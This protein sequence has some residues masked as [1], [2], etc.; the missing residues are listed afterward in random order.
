[1][2]IKKIIPWK[3]KP[4]FLKIK[5]LKA[6][7]YKNKHNFKHLKIENIEYKLKKILHVIYQFHINNKIILFIGVPTNLYK[8]MTQLLK[9]TKHIAIPHGIWLNGAI[10]NHHTVLKYLLRLKRSNKA[11]TEILFQ[12]KKKADLII[13]LDKQNS[14]T[15]LNEGS[16]SKITTISL[17]S[18]LNTLS[19]KA[20][21]N[22]PGNFNFI[23][24]KITNS[25][26]YTILKAT[27]KKG[28]I[29]N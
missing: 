6:Q 25:F 21:Y 4:K 23:S 14:K 26:I 5:L 1:M 7:T 22:V 9:G 28:R 19:N 29:N 27:L 2:K 12:L 8:Q 16:L 24:K 18:D 17:G 10:T 15:I 20:T 3:H 13:T 11:Q